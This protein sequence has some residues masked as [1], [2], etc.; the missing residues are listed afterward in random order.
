MNQL[1]RISALVALVPIP[2]PLIWARKSSSSMSCPAFSIAR[3]IDPELYLFG[4]EVSPSLIVNSFTGNTVPFSLS[5]AVQKVHVHVTFRILFTRISG[6]DHFQISFLCQNLEIG[7]KAFLFDLGCNTDFL[8]NSRRIENTQKPSDNRV[9]Y[10]P[11][12]M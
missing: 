5:E 9:V 2:L 4:G 1:F 11:C 3:I 8:I 7:E 10:L 6:P 12:S